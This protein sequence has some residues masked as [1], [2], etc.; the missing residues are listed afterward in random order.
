[1]ISVQSWCRDN[2]H[3]DQILSLWCWVSE[4]TP[5]IRICKIINTLGHT[6]TISSDFKITIWSIIL[7]VMHYVHFHENGFVHWQIAAH[8]NH[9]SVGCFSCTLNNI[10]G[11]ILLFKRICKLWFV[12]KLWVRKSLT[13]KKNMKKSMEYMQILSHYFNIYLRNY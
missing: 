4:E 5:I 7:R 8:Q 12:K 3:V 6:A 13:S 10:E 2:K 9:T 11:I 1:M